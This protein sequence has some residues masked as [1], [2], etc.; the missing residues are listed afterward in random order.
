MDKHWYLRFLTGQSRRNS[1][2]CNR[3][4]FIDSPRGP[5]TVPTGGAFF[6]L[7]FCPKPLIQNA[8]IFEFP[9][10]FQ[11]KISQLVPATAA[12]DL[13]PRHCLTLQ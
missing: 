5:V 8:I 7:I 11:S 10:C 2:G 9:N 13:I 1:L 4:R 6:L 3:E 12:A